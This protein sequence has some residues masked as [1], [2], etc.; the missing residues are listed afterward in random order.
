M[1]VLKAVI[2]KAFAEN[3]APVTFDRAAV[4]GVIRIIA[5]GAVVAVAVAVNPKTV[6]VGV[7]GNLKMEAARHPASSGPNSV[8][9]VI[10]SLPTVSS[11][12]PKKGLASCVRPR[13]ILLPNLRTFS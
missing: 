6:V 8:R 9:T 10:R 1:G 5:S 12:S 3:D 4:M 2:Q 11:K 7:A 13:A